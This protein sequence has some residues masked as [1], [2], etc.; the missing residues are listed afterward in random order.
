MSYLKLKKLM[1][2]GRLAELGPAQASKKR[3]APAAQPEVAA[4]SD[5]GSAG[6]SA[7]GQSW[8]AMAEENEQA[9]PRAG[10]FRRDASKRAR[11]RNW[12]KSRQRLRSA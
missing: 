12:E 1:L 9:P 10:R 4:A 11:S 3:P 6:V 5:T 8:E 2:R 7:G